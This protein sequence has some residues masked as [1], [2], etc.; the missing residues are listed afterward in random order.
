MSR[1]KML[2][3]RDDISK[4]VITHGACFHVFFNVCLHS[5]WFSALCWLVEIWQLSQCGATGELAAEFKF[6]RHS[7]K[8]SFLFSALLPERLGAFARRLPLWLL[9]NQRCH[10]SSRLLYL[11]HMFNYFLKALVNEMGTLQDMDI[12]PPENDEAGDDFLFPDDLEDL[13]SDMENNL[14]EDSISIVSTPKPSLRY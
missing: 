7:C 2:I 1:C 3:G 9:D 14:L 12:S 11:T 13:D 8:L 5:C 6:Q 4:D 10:H